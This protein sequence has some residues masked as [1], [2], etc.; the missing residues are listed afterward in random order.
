LK[1]FFTQAKGK[2]KIATK[3]NGNFNLIVGA[4]LEI[5]HDEKMEWQN[6]LWCKMTINQPAPHSWKTK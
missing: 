4:V 2:D 3:I 5:T 1:I 6:Y